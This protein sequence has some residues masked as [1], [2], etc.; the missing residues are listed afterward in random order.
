MDNRR[1]EVSDA[2][3]IN[4]FDHL[5]AFHRPPVGVSDACQINDFDHSTGRQARHGYVSD[6]CQINDF[7]HSGE[8]AYLAHVSF[9]CLSDQ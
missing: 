5:G 4:D 7:D 6:A 2:C 1:T 8:L 3:Q 9:R